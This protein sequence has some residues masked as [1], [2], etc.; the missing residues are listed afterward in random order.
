MRTGHVDHFIEESTEGCSGDA[1]GRQIRARE[2][3]T[4]RSKKRIEQFDVEGAAE[5]QRL[6]ESQKRLE[7]LQAPQLVDASA[8]VSRL[9]QMVLDVQRQLQGPVALHSKVGRGPRPTTE[10]E[11][12][13]WLADEHGVDGWESCGSRTHLWIDHVPQGQSHPWSRTWSDDVGCEV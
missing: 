11:I 5:V 4:E 6:E 10:E 9:Q 3:F 7:E 8:E 1:V 13:E 12:L 2:A